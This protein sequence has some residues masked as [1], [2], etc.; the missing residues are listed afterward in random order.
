MRKFYYVI[1][2]SIFCSTL[3]AQSWTNVFPNSGAEYFNTFAV[4]PSST[5]LYL[6]T[7][8]GATIRRSSDGGKNWSLI[9]PVGLPT[10]SQKSL[11]FCANSGALIVCGSASVGGGFYRSTDHGDNFTQIT[12]VSGSKVKILK[13]GEIVVYSP[14]SMYADTYISKDNGAN[15]T[16]LNNHTTTSKYAI[17]VTLS[18][19]TYYAVLNY[20]STN[21]LFKST[22]SGTTWTAITGANLP[23]DG[24]YEKVTST[25]NGDLYVHGYAVITAKSADGGSTW[26]VPTAGKKHTDLYPDANGNLFGSNP[27]VIERSANGGTTWVSIADGLGAP[28]MGI[29]AYNSTL[30]GVVYT[31]DG[32]GRVYRYT[33]VGATNPSVGINE[34]NIS[35]DEVCVYPIPANNF[36]NIDLA[37]HQT[38]IVSV[39]IIDIT[40][41]LVIEDN[42]VSNNKLDITSLDK[43]IYFVNVLLDN[44]TSLNKK[45]VKE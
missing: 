43:G 17:D 20:N 36:L 16:I 44:Q 23:T 3:K 7:T 6:G 33:G 5:Y 9:T 4:D 45:I 28:A 42:S 1:A 35:S 15:W 10:F 19:T 27:S 8:S 25:L 38:K 18:G 21:G 14:A 24:Y 12:G 31:A 41:K 13:N 26:T 30:S 34:Q 39:K 2:L 11:L 22:N 29:G 37:N 40:G 32:Y